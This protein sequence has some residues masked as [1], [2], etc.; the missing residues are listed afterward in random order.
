[1]TPWHLLLDGRCP[2]QGTMAR[3]IELFDA[4]RSGALPGALRIYNWAEPAVTIGYH[5]RSFTL[6]DPTLAVP[7]LQRPTGG[8]AVLHGDDITF[9]LSCTRDGL[10]P[11]GILESSMRISGLF[12]HAFDRCGLPVQAKGGPHGF[13]EVC[14]ARPSPFELMHKGSKLMGLA[15]AKKGRF[16]LVQG[17][18]PLRVNQALTGRVFGAR[19]AC[20]PRGVMDYLPD[21]SVDVFVACLREGFASELGILLHE[22]DKEDQKGNDADGCKVDPR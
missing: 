19:L 7:V 4:V 16:L 18:I 20:S 15:L 10:F 14:F 5:Q 6:N 3:D 11:S 13:S 1:M 8:G 9:S 17:V 2:A 12:S 22:C 21:F